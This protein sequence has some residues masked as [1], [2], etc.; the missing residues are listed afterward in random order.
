M[1]PQQNEFYDDSNGFTLYDED[2][3][4]IF[5][6]SSGLTNGYKFKN[7]HLD[8]SFLELP[9]TPPDPNPNLNTEPGSS[10]VSSDI[11]SQEDSPDEFND[12][13]FNYIDQIL[14]EENVEGIQSLFCDPLEL[15]ATER[16]L[17][18]ALG[19][20]YPSPSQSPLIQLCPN[21]ENSEDFFFRSSGEYSTTTNSTTSYSNSTHPDWP[22]GYY[23]DSFSS[24][25][26]SHP[27]EYPPTPLWSLG[28]STTSVSNDEMQNT[29]MSH[30]I[31]TDSESIK[32]FNR[33]MEEASKFLPSTKPLVIDL[34][35]YD[36]PQDSRN[37][38]PEVVV[39][40]EK[41]KT[42]NGVKGRKHSQLE[43][44]DYEE[45]RSSKQSAVYV[46]EDELSE[47]FDRVLLGAD[48]N[49]KF[50]SCCQEET[51]LVEQMSVKS[52]KNGSTGGS[53]NKRNARKNNDKAVDIST[54]L[55]SCAQAVA[56]GD[57]RSA[58]EQLNQIRQHASTSGDASQRLAHVFATAIEARLAGTGSHLYAATCSL[59][60]SAAE[61]LRAY[62]VYL[63]ACPFK[64]IAMS[65]AN[66]MIFDAGLASSNSTLHIVDF[67]IAY[68]FQWP[69]FIKHL[70]EVPNGP[71]KLK[72]TGI[73]YPQPGF[74]PAER[75]EETGRRLANYCERFN[76]PFEYNA[77][78]SQNWETIRVEDL[79]LQRNEFLAVNS[80][81]RFQN[82]LDETVS[83][84]SPRDKVLKLIRDMKPDI[85]VHSVVNGAYSAPFFVTRFRETL[86]H[87]SALFDMFDATLERENEQR[88]NFE[89]EFYG[90]EA[91]NVIAC[92]GAERVERPESY[93]QWQVRLSR[94]GFKLKALNQEMISKLRWKR[95]CYHKDFVFDEDG[96][97]ILQGWKGRILYA[98]SCWVPV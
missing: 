8:L 12:C 91:M 31:F 3:L 77:I 63:S 48:A 49:G 21:T 35:K 55:V 33:G 58:N 84:E 95:A 70:S 71:P 30:N 23:F 47:M 98:S 68:G 42:S 92:E 94:A 46:E 27:L 80:L 57:Q 15:Q 13:V 45:E 86:F 4:P 53:N 79:K 60:L 56:A 9:R 65:F 29:H 51:V 90:R 22:G 81:I 5:N 25:T 36:L 87:Y 6:Q 10:S 2:I 72:I 16:S 24:A 38:P 76:V 67:G 59:R 62:Q 41:A 69:I 50:T 52:Q 1:E 32:Q 96:K 75:L 14:V 19:A 39:K 26:Q 89:K 54:L 66:K 85:F 37:A 44:N 64:K 73:E 17:Y 61:K 82:L 78:A 74:R 34:D 97:W 83:V 43:D 11:H 93:K 20:K 40:V 28:S 88:L 7:E 18:E